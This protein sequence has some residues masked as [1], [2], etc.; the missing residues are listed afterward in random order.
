MS[1][2]LSHGEYVIQWRRSITEVDRLEWDV[3]ALPQQS[4]FLEWEWLKLLEDSS[5]VGPEAGWHPMH[6]TVHRAGV[7]VGAAP[8]Y[9]KWDCYGEF[10]FDHVWADVAGK[11]GV[12]YFPKCVGAVPFTPVSGYRFLI[13]PRQEE[14][15]VS[16]LMLQA[17]KRMCRDNGIQSLHFHFVD[18]AWAGRMES[19]GLLRWDHQAFQWSHE[20]LNSFDDY[21]QGFKSGQ[22]KNI[23]HERRALQEHGITVRTLTGDQV[24]RE[25]LAEMHRFYELTN[26]KY[27]PWNCKFLTREFFLRLGDVYRSRL[28]MFMAFNEDQAPVGASLLVFKGDRLYG[29]YWGCDGDLPHLH[30]NLCFYHPIEWAI[31]HG[32]RF[33]DPGIGAAHKVR[34]GF[35]SVIGSS[36]HLFFDVQMQKIFELNIGKIN[37]HT[38]QQVEALNSLLPLKR[39]G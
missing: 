23:K 37:A 39:S 21:L 27:A 33:F 2:T 31:H 4:P 3:L 20:N 17:L 1:R 30:F 38:R 19:L 28:L 24:T 35:E 5:S 7:L 18:E 16:G 8:L 29:R 25:A 26:D 22:R 32:I 14:E 15:L 6:L 12:R 11:I 9:L 13:H 34:R 10:V 36:L